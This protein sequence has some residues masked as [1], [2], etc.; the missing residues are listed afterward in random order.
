MSPYRTPAKPEPQRGPRW[1]ATRWRKFWVK[2]PILE[3]VIFPIILAI[4]F[5]P[6]CT[7]RMLLGEDPLGW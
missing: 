4:I 7:I 3:C 6:V 2:H 1:G 5:I